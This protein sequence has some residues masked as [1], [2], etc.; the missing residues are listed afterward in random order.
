MNSIKFIKVIACPVDSRR[1]EIGG[2]DGG[3][4]EVLILIDKVLY[5]YKDVNNRFSIKLDPDYE[6]KIL[7]KIYSIKT[8]FTGLFQQSDKF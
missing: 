5:I 6:S 7:L 1:I 8:D 3:Q 4:R 2:L